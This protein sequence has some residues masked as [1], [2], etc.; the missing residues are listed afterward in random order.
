[1][2]QVTSCRSPAL[3]SQTY[4]RSVLLRFYVGHD[5]EIIPFPMIYSLFAFFSPVLIDL[6]KATLYSMQ[7]FQGWWRQCTR[8]QFKPV[9]THCWRQRHSV[10]LLVPAGTSTR[11][12]WIQCGFKFLK[13]GHTGSYA[14]WHRFGAKTI[15]RFPL[16]L[17]TL[18][19]DENKI[20]TDESKTPPNRHFG[21]LNFVQRN[22]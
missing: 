12:D 2:T 13:I 14:T 9:S 1:L 19:I 15:C 16:P 7:P 3:S 18:V 10:T 21:E 5:P 17:V 22:I 20:S 6:L 11:L 8:S 4:W